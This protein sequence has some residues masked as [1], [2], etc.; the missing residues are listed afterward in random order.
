MSRIIVPI[1]HPNLGPQKTRLSADIAASAT[2]ATVENNDGLASNDYIVYGKPGQ[3]KTE[4]VIL[5][6]VTG[7]TTISHSTG[8][9]FAHSAKTP[10]YEIGYNQVE[11]SSASSETGSYSVLDTIDLTLDEE[12]TSY[13]DA[14]GTTSTWYKVRYY[15]ETTTDYSDYSVAVQG[16]GYVEDSLRDMTDEILEEMGEDDAV[17]VTRKQIRRYLNTAIRKVTQKVLELNPDYLRAYTTQQLTSGVEAYDLPTRFQ[18]FIRV[19]IN[20]SS[21]VRADGYKV[22][23]FVGEDRGFPDTNYFEEQPQIAIRGDQFIIRPTPTSSNGYAFIHYFE[24]PASLVDENDTHGLPYGG[25]DL[26]V[27]Y[28]LYRAYLPK[29]K[30]LAQSYSS[31]FTGSLKDYAQFAATKRQSYDNKTV[32]ATFGEDMYV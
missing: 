23:D 2:S 15:N 28:A 11:I 10:I 18:A 24:Y 9:V 8:P 30:E 7:N 4:I 31:E 12:Y 13:I 19:D 14:S 27:S 6:G 32:Q 5:T 16:T 22:E 21:S 17:Y 29:D 3:E 26:L 25:R 1:S 20:F